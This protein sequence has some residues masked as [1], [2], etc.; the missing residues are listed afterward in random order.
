VSSANLATVERVYALWNRQDVV[1]SG[2]P[3]FA[4]DCEFVNPESAIEGGTR[5]GVEG[6]IGA[7]GSVD[8]AF[9]E[10]THVLE[11]MVEAGDDK[12]LAYVRFQAKGRDSRVPVEIPEQHVWTFR[13]GLIV[14]FE[15][16]HDEAAARHAAGL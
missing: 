12:V 8:A 16:F 13:D 14:R 2:L 6:F 11:R 3:M 9:D 1:D 15:W 4:D 7:L 5:Q 10:H